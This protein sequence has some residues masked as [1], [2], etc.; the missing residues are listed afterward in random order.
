IL[1][2]EKY[3]GN[4]FGIFVEPS[5]AAAWAG[6]EKYCNSTPK[7]NEKNVVILTGCGLKDSKS[8]EKA[9]NI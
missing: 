4:K 5:A 3:I 8:A 9:V 1:K 6:F 7:K 2:S